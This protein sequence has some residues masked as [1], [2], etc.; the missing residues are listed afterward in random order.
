LASFLAVTTRR[1]IKKTGA[2]SIETRLFISLLPPDPVRLAAAVR[3]HWSVENNLHWVLDVAFRED[4]CRVRKDHSARNLAM[5]RR[6]VLNMLRRE[7]SK[8]SLKRKRL[9]ALMNP[10]YRQAVLAG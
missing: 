10:T 9:K 6:A 4:E 8:T 3:A 7:P 5:I 1:T 2:V